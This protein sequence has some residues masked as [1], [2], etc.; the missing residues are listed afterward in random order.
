M[1]TG[2]HHAVH[3]HKR[4]HHTTNQSAITRFI[5]HSAYLMGAITIAVNVPQLISVWTAPSTAGVSLVSWIGFLLGSV[6][7]LIYG[8]LH[9]EK[10]IIVIN[11]GLIIIQGLIVLGLAI[12]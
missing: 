2:F 6:F 3:H 1:Q 12:R 9:R 11:G 7:W 8:L 10:P 5:D 4:K